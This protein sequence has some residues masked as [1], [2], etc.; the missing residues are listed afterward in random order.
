MLFE[1]LRPSPQNV[2]AREDAPAIFPRT[3]RTSPR[4]NAV[5][6]HLRALREARGLSQGAVAHEAGLS[7]AALSNYERGQREVTLSTAM[8]LAAALDVTLCQ[9]IDL[10]TD[11]LIVPAGSRLAR[12]VEVLEESPE[13]LEQVLGGARV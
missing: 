8:R 6:H 13:L 7:Q 9:L 5:S 2:A 1:D 11:H 12:A 3:M 4:T 10:E